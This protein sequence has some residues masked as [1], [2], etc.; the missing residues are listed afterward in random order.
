MGNIIRPWA[1]MGL[2]LINEDRYSLPVIKIIP[3]AVLFVRF[4]VRGP[5]NT[6]SHAASVVHGSDVL[7]AAATLHFRKGACCHL[8]DVAEHE[9]HVGPRG[10]C[11]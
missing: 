9:L 4:I 8:L 1:F 5:V 10:F 2:S 3:C 7:C 11:D 6:R